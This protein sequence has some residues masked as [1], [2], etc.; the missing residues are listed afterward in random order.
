MGYWENLEEGEEEEEDEWKKEGKKKSRGSIPYLSFFFFFAFLLSLL[1]FFPYFSLPGRRPSLI[2]QPVDHISRLN[3]SLSLFPLL[4]GPH[5]LQLPEP[6][7]I[8]S[9]FAAESKRE[10]ERGLMRNHEE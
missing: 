2:I 9:S 8:S 5:G 1:M 4:K 3:I 6:T 10:G 7:E